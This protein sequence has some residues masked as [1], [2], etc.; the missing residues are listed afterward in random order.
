MPRLNTLIDNFL[1]WLNE[2]SLE[3]C[4]RRGLIIWEHD[5]TP[6]QNAEL[7]AKS[8]EYKPHV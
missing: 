3:Q 5:L 1:L 8:T 7:K 6:E 4:D 2:W